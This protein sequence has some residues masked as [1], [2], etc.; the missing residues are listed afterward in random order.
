VRIGYADSLTFDRD[1]E[2]RIF[3]DAERPPYGYW[4]GDLS[5]EKGRTIF[6]SCMATTGIQN[7]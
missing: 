5:F 3:G 2:H 7:F 1:L 6:R 4:Y